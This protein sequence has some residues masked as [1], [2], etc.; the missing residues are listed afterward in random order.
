MRS[1]G[2]RVLG[3]APLVA[4]RCV[5]WGSELSVTDFLSVTRVWWRHRWGKKVLEGI[6]VCVLLASD[7]PDASFSHIGLSVNPVVSFAGGS[8]GNFR[9]LEAGACSE[10]S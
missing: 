2:R 5:C 1:E 9:S 10:Y 4:L 3:V 7:L 6:F 8:R